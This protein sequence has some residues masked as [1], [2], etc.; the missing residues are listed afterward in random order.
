MKIRARIKSLESL[1]GEFDPEGVYE[2]SLEEIQRAVEF[3][4]EQGVED[5]RDLDERELIRKL[6]SSDLAYDSENEATE[7]INHAKS[8]RS[9]LDFV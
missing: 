1:V 2:S 6:E 8:I 7:A 9:A 4:E 3:A 5:V